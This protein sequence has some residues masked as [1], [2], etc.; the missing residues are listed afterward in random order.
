MPADAVASLYDEIT[1]AFWQYGD[2]C[3]QPQADYLFEARDADGRVLGCHLPW[4]DARIYW[5]AGNDGGGTCDRID[6]TPSEP[7]EF[8]GQ[9][10]HWVFTKNANTGYMRM[11]LNGLEWYS[12]GPGYT[13][14]LEGITTFKIGSDASGTNNYD[15]ILNDFRIYSRELTPEDVVDIYCEGAGCTPDMVGYW[16]FNEGQG[17]ITQDCSIN[18]NDGTITGA[19]WVT[20]Q[21]DWALDFQDT[22]Y[23]SV[24]SDVFASV[25]DEITITFW[26]YGD[27]AIQ[28]QG[29][30]LFEAQDAD[31]RVLACHLPW[32][33]A[34]I[35]WDAG[36]DSGGAADRIYKTA[37]QSSEFEGQ[38]NHW[39]LTKNAN[40]GY[41]RM[42]L[43]GVPWHSDG[44]GYTRTMEGI[45]S[46]KIGSDIDGTNNYDGIIDNFRVYSRELT[47]R[48]NRRYLRRHLA[49]AHTNDV[50]DNRN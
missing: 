18:D 37:S 27:D 41:M 33:D 8:E 35:Y 21:D 40:T 32:S 12:D 36:N 1:I 11:Y 2:P 44:P 23:V 38:W 14:T 34:R 43:N 28:P 16:Q 19:T 50:F 3:I 30:Y 47:P 48:R 45:T 24:S 29:D 42:Y 22:D 13:G 5:D 49:A 7:A 9:W 6:D 4:A 20:G 17:V 31:G 26:Q 10:N 15:G 46:F 25:A 39:A